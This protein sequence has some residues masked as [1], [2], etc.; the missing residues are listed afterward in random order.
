M[1]WLARVGVAMLVASSAALGATAAH[2]ADYPGRPVRLVVPFT[3]GGTLDIVA[4]LVATKLRDVWHQPVVVDNRVG[5]NGAVAVEYVVNSKPDGLTLLYNGSL[6]AVIQ[7]VQR[8]PFD[9]NRDLIPVVQPVAYLQVL[10][11]NS[12]LGVTSIAELLALARREPGRLNY[13]SGGVGS[14]LHL[15]MELVKSSAHV[16]ITHVP[17]KGNAPAIQALMTGEVDMVF[18]TVGGMLPAIRSGRVRPLMVTG[19]RPIDSLPDVPTMESVMPGVMSDA[20]WH[21]IF[22]PTGTPRL[23]VDQIATDVRT[24]VFSPDIVARL[25]DLEFLPTGLDSVAF[26]A[27]IRKDFDVWG[28]LIRE[29]NIHAD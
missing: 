17:Y 29:K 15:Y 19:P 1:M 6:L 16:E 11:V 2:A 25:R 24:V 18:D 27:V 8:T 20:G 23:I 13:G 21:G 26:A 14:G 28:N 12:K 4:R 3:A 9:I 22:V 5:G 7:Q 10:G